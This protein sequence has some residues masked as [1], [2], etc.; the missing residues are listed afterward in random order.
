MYVCE[1]EPDKETEIEEKAC[2]RMQECYDKQWPLRK[3]I[4]KQAKNIC[5]QK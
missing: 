3:C 2:V 1:M 5:S 4:Q